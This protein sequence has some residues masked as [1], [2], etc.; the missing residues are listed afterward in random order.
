MRFCTSSIVKTSCAR[1]LGLHEIEEMAVCV[2][3]PD[4][5]V[6]GPAPGLDPIDAEI[7]GW[8]AFDL[9]KHPGIVGVVIHVVMAFHSGDEGE[10]VFFELKADEFF[11]ADVAHC[12]RPSR[13]CLV[14][15]VIYGLSDEVDPS[16]IGHGKGER[17]SQRA[18]GN[19]DS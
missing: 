11:R 18:G 6:L 15:G 5:V 1:V 14:P 2:P 16:S 4:S 13:I 9:W 19:V 7:V 3:I 17:C 8:V 12:L 10:E